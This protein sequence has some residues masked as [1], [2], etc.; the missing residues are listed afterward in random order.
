MFNHRTPNIEL[1][2][3][4]PDR[5]EGGIV[6]EVAGATNNGCGAVIVSHGGINKTVHRM[7]VN[8][9]TLQL[10][11]KI[12]SPR[13][14]GTTAREAAGTSTYGSWCLDLE[15]CVLLACFYSVFIS[16]LGTV[17]LQLPEWSRT[18]GQKL[19]AYRVGVQTNI[20][21]SW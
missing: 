2:D 4:I 8:D 21:T 13:S 16:H 3:L 9:R 19:M 18:C 1:R 5:L 7:D 12:P 11:S 10:V 20:K 6:L 15:G 14:Q 17:C